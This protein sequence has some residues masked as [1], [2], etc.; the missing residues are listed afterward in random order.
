MMVDQGGLQ[1]AA[2]GRKVGSPRASG[3]SRFHGAW[4]CTKHRCRLPWNSGRAGS[5]ARVSTP[6]QQTVSMIPSLCVHVRTLVRA[7]PQKVSGAPL[8]T[9]LSPLVPAPTE[10]TAASG[11]PPCVHAFVLPAP[12]A[13]AF[14]GHIGCPLELRSHHRHVEATR[15]RAKPCQLAIEDRDAW[16]SMEEGFVPEAQHLKIKSRTFLCSGV[17]LPDMGA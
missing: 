11:R 9:F 1:H 16:A 4:T 3:R 13:S 6:S 15:E 2:R 5:C 10:T 12:Q 14:S 7:P 8:Q 17:M